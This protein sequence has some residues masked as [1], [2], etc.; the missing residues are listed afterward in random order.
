MPLNTPVK[1]TMNNRLD[2]DELHCVEQLPKAIRRAN[3]PD[4]RLTGECEHRTDQLEDAD[5][6]LTQRAPQA[7]CLVVFGELCIGHGST[8]STEL[9]EDGARTAPGRRKRSA[10]RVERQR[11]EQGVPA[12][13]VD[14][15]SP[16]S[17]SRMRPSSRCESKPSSR[18]CES[19]FKRY[20]SACES[21][22]VVRCSCTRVKVGLGTRASRGRPS[23]AAQGAR[24]KRLS[25]AERAGQNHQIA[26]LQLGREQLSQALGRATRRQLEVQTGWVGGIGHGRG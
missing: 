22:G 24:K 25:R 26:R 8:L 19:P 23:A 12:E 4:Q 14:V 20:K 10:A 16:H 6:G 5:Q 1:A 11:E 7:L 3:Q 13:D 9:A 2:P 21:G 15:G 18:T 17:T